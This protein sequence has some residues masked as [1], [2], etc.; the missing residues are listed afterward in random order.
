MVAKRDDWP[1]I[2][3]RGDEALALANDM[4]HLD[5]RG[6]PTRDFIDRLATLLRSCRVDPK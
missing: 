1:G 5:I 3:I 2:F 6:L 4:S